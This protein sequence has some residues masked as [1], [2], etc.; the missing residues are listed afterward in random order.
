MLDGL[1]KFGDLQSSRIRSAVDARAGILGITAVVKP[2][3]VRDP[4]STEAAKII[5]KR[6]RFGTLPLDDLPHDQWENYPSGAWAAIPTIALYWCDGHR[7]L[8]EVIRL[9]RL[10]LGPTDFDFLGYFGLLRRLASACVQAAELQVLPEYLRTAP[11]GEIVPADRAAAGE[12]RPSSLA[13]ARMGYVSLHVI[14]KLGSPGDYSLELTRATGLQVDVF[15]E[16]YHA[17]DREKTYYPDALAPVRMPYSS[18][19]PEP[20]NRIPGQKAQAFWVDVWIPGSLPRSRS[21]TWWPSTTILT[22][23]RGS[24]TSTRGNANARARTSSAATL[25]S[26]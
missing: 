21:R 4:Q 15:R 25:S 3:A 20:D 2:A 9:T 26:N 14:A 24:A 19:L 18:R 1:R 7:N 10:E 6:K 23:V 11:D 12:S 13:G 8:A 17:L 5:V 22:A 16:W